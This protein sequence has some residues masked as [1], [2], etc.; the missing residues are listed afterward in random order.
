MQ[1]VVLLF[2]LIQIAFSGRILA[3]VPV[4]NSEPQPIL[5]RNSIYIELAGNAGAA[6][7]LNYERLI[8]FTASNKTL[9][10]RV[11][12]IYAVNGNLREDYNYELLVPLEASVL[13]G[14][15]AV[16]LELGFGITLDRYFWS[17]VDTLGER[18]NHSTNEFVPLLR[19]GGRWQKPGKH[20][21]VRVGFTPILQEHYTAIKFP[22]S[23]WAGIS[24]G[25]N[26]GK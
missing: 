12:G 3:Q 2:C 9:V 26:F 19:I 24:V 22:F 11:G 20:W 18:I 21:F 15:K 17:N 5:Y 23:P 1:K 6:P 16:K 14:Q 7:S 8:P 4:F 25:Y 13:L 10:L